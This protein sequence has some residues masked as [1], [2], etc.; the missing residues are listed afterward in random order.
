MTDPVSRQIGTISR[1]RNRSTISPLSRWTTSPL[2]T[3]QARRKSLLQQPR[4]QPIAARRRIAE[5]ELL[6]RFRGDAALG[7]LLPR[8]RSGRARQL[9]A[10][11]LGRDLV[12]L[13]QRFAQRGIIGARLRRFL[14]CA[15]AA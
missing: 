4:F 5:P 15:R 14:R 11:V 13:Q 7:E 8:P 10:K 9:F 6:D 12:H 3:T 1:L 2:W